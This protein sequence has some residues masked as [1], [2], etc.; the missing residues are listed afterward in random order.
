[1][2][3]IEVTGGRKKERDVVFSTV[4][5]CIDILMPRVRTLDIEVSLTNCDSHGYCL[6]TDDHKTF[7][8]EIKRNLGFHDLVTT[9]CHE[10]IHVK[11]YY[12]KELKALFGGG[13][14]WYGKESNEDYE[15]LPWEIEAHKLEKSLAEN[16]IIN[17]HKY[18]GNNNEHILYIGRT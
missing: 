3:Y 14:T 1:M 10:M 8:L 11:Q 15:N 9:V 7:E 16:V 2:N 12:R 4:G 5:A 6:N 18:T 17:I 13:S